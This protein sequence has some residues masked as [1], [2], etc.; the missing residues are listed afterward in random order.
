MKIKKIVSN[1]SLAMAIWWVWLLT[2]WLSEQG[3][4]VNILSVYQSLIYFIDSPFKNH[5]C[6]YMHVFSK[7]LNTRQN[8]PNSWKI[9]CVPP[10]FG[11]SQPKFRNVDGEDIHFRILFNCFSILCQTC[12]SISTFLINNPLK[13]AMKAQILINHLYLLISLSYWTRQD[14]TTLFK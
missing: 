7:Y 5:E 10:K 3:I 12:Y 4:F 8:K 13:A 11:A 2:E 1:P 14:K 6:K 9:K